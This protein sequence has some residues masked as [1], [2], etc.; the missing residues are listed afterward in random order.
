M[1]WFQL[2]VNTFTLTLSFRDWKTI[3]GDQKCAPSIEG[4]GLMESPQVFLLRY[5]EP[6]HRQETAILQM[7]R[8]NVFGAGKLVRAP[9]Q[10]TACRWS[11]TERVPYRSQDFEQI[12]ISCTVS[13]FCNLPD[14][15]PNECPSP[16][17]ITGLSIP[18]S[19]GRCE[20]PTDEGLNPRP[21]WH[22]PEERTAY[23]DSCGRVMNDAMVAGLFW[24]VSD[25]A[26]R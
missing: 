21:L 26:T 20:K 12:Y 3:E 6:A 23:T 5:W 9:T 7:A 25:R 17:V 22:S 14:L 16:Q 4:R 24:R 15:S 2:S 11:K 10:W 19:F 13:V 1:D 18:P 8:A